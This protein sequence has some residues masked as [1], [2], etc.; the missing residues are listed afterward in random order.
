MKIVNLVKSKHQLIFFLTTCSVA[1]WIIS[2]WWTNILKKYD[3]LIIVGIIYILLGILLS[4]TI[5][6][7]YTLKTFA[8]NIKK[9]PI[10]EYIKILIIVF[11]M[12]I[13]GYLYM[14]AVF[15]F[16]DISTI[17]ITDFVSSMIVNILVI[18]LFYNNKFTTTFFIGIIL[19]CVGG[20][21]VI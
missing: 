8:T 19:L 5:R 21:L 4:I 17:R 9:I 7:R 3:P 6:K 11:G 13:F 2:W 15:M 10:M 16:H 18:Y 1:Y 12:C 20:Y 14:K